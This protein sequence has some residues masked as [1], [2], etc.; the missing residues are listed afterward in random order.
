MEVEIIM[1]QISGRLVLSNHVTYI[2]AWSDPSPLTLFLAR[3]QRVNPNRNLARLFLFLVD[4]GCFTALT[5]PARC[6]GAYEPLSLSE[7]MQIWYDRMPPFGDWMLHSQIIREIDS[8]KI[9]HECTLH[10]TLFTVETNMLIA[11]TNA[12]QLPTAELLMLAAELGYEAV[13]NQDYALLY[14]A[15]RERAEALNLDE[16]AF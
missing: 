5:Y 8:E 3:A 1:P 12:Q 13:R 2:A 4:M 10:S 11:H 7:A 6:M 16:L 14:G 15:L 9:V